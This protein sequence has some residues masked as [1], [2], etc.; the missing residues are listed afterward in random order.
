MNVRPL[1]LQSSLTISPSGRCPLVEEVLR[2]Y[3][4]HTF[5]HIA[6]RVAPHLV[7]GN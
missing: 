3:D 1:R 2:N 5:I 6:S 7:A 4:E